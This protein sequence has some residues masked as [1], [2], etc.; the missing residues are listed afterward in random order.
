M[1]ISVLGGTGYFFADKSSE[2]EYKTKIDRIL[3]DAKNKSPKFVI[4]LPDGLRIVKS[5]E[6]PKQGRIFKTTDERNA[7]NTEVVRL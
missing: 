1:L 6:T 2:P 3:F 7:R 5:E 4:T